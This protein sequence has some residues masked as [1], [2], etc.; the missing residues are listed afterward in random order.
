MSSECD[1]NFD[2]LAAR[3]RR[4]V[5]GSLKG[6]IRLS[7]L[8]RDFKEFIPQYFENSDGRS[9]LDVAAGE[10]LFS[11]RLH[12][13]GCSLVVNDVSTEMLKFA[14]ENFQQGEMGQNANARKSVA[15][16]QCAMQDLENTLP[17]LNLPGK[18]DLV[19]CH[20]L[21]EWMAKPQT[22]IPYLKQR[23][24]KGGHLSL[25]FYNING[26]AFKNLLRT[27]FHKFDIEDFSAFRGSLTPAHP[28]TPSVVLQQLVNEGFTV[29]C[30]SGIRT[31]HDYIL[32][33]V[34]RNREPEALLKKE[35]DYSRREPFWQMARYIHYLCRYD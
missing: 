18:Y 27:N 26:L 16:V 34:D 1:R 28:Q 3:F 12:S 7:V 19:L 30:K 14:R 4:N 13:Y 6:K 2:G 10:A 5:Y 15:I 35:L 11:S 8:E 25:T 23:V 20:A 21:M 32:N 29:L 31:F 24:T 22:L 33:P 17:N 9:V